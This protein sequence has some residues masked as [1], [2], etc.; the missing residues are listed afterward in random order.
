LEVW[1]HR[2][3][4]QGRRERPLLAESVSTSTP[5]R[6]NFLQRRRIGTTPLVRLALA[7]LRRIEDGDENGGLSHHSGSVGSSQ[8]PV[9][10]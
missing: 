3:G 1:H 5:R 8:A 2:G 6:L 9:Q 4:A 7:L 10:L